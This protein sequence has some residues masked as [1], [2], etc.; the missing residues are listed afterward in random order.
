MASESSSGFQDDIASAL[1]I[2]QS[3]GVTEASAK[4]ILMPADC[5]ASAIHGRAN[6]IKSIRA[7]LDVLFSNSENRIGFM[8]MKNDNL[9]F[10]GLTPLEKIMQDPSSALE[11]CAARISALSMGAL[12]T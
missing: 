4:E 9:Y 10:G 11:D 1:S 2:L 7:N 12:G 8:S 5:A 3:W 6:L